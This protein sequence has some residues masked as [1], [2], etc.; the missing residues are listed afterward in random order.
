MTELQQL[1][2]DLSD[3]VNN[4]TTQLEQTKAKGET[5]LKQLLDTRH[6]L[7]QKDYECENQK[8]ALELLKVTLERYETENK[9]LRGLLSLWL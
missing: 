3:E 1:V 9:H 5:Y 2:H 8:K 6:E 4:L 7:I